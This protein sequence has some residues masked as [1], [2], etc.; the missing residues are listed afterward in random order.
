MCVCVTECVCVCVCVRAT[1]VREAGGHPKQ[2]PHM[3][4]WGRTKLH[5]LS[6]CH[7]VDDQEG[8]SSK[9]TDSKDVW[10][11]EASCW[12]NLRICGLP[13]LHFAFTSPRTSC[14]QPPLPK[15]LK[16][17]H[18]RLLSASGG[19]A[20]VSGFRVPGFFKACSVVG[21]LWDFL[22]SS[23]SGLNHDPRLL[24]G[25]NAP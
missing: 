23:G 9:I 15:H 2:D 19:L 13:P 10:A 16:C 8:E 18:L 22:G 17:I 5:M 6:P 25:R 20:M 12:M 14:L 24:A 7:Q 3:V 4:M 11:D 21:V 1:V